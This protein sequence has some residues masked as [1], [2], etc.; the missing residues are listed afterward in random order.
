MRCTYQAAGET[1]QNYLPA[2]DPTA[3]TDSSI[4]PATTS[5]AIDPTAPSDRASAIDPASG[6]GVWR[7]GN[8]GAY[9]HCG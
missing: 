6:A 1:R 4:N 5:T 8:P 3:P 7:G 9:P 2:V